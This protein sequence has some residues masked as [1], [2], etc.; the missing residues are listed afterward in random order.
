MLAGK[1]FSIYKNTTVERIKVCLI[2]FVRYF[3]HKCY[4]C[5]KYQTFYEKQ[6]ELVT[7]VSNCIGTYRK[8]Y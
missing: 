6:P 5:S 7:Q 3:N 1:N 4:F 8:E 2:D